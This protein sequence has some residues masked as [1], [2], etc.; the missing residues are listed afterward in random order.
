[1]PLDT[2]PVVTTDNQPATESMDTPHEDTNPDSEVLYTMNIDTQKVNIVVDKESIGKSDVATEPLV[3]NITVTLDTRKEK[4]TDVHNDSST[5][6]SET[7]SI[8]EKLVV[9]NTKK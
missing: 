9:D 7:G 4:T 8:E 6:P 3:E 2:P 1:M 5:E